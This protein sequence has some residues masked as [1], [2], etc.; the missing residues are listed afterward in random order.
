MVGYHPQVILSGRRINDGMGP[1]VA[2]QTIKLLIRIGC[3][4]RG[5]K[6]NV[7]GLTF[8]ENC[9]DLRNSKVVDIVRELLDY[10]CEVAV[11]DPVA[12]PEDAMREYGI[13]LASWEALPQCDALVAAVAHRDYQSMPLAELLE[14]VRLRPDG[15][16]MDVKSA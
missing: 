11:H 2:Q 3:Q 12:N 7:L 10:G 4:I 1:Y 8:K 15:V 14:K 16:F 5:S 6:V 13:R 9:A